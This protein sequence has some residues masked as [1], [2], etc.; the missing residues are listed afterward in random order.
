MLGQEQ[1]TWKLTVGVD[2]DG[3]GDGGG[4]A[5]RGNEAAKLI[6]QECEER[7]RLRRLTGDG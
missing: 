2:D 7:T 3:D 5:R 4:G 1:T 6:P